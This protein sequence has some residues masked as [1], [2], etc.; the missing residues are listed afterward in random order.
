D[1]APWMRAPAPP[2]AP[3]ARPARGDGGAPYQHS[4]SPAPCAARYKTN[5]YRG[6]P[7][8]LPGLAVACDRRPTAR[9]ARLTRGWLTPLP[10]RSGVPTDGWPGRHVPA[11][12]RG[13]A[14]R[15]RGQTVWLPRADVSRVD[16]T[17]APQS[18]HGLESLRDARAPHDSRPTP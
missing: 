18:A 1:S 11:V 10:R 14:T 5:G 2:S 7:P 9:R 15:P 6:R 4:G 16:D 8:T 17:H 12:R 13:V 3:R